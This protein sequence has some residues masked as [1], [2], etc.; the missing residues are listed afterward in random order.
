MFKLFKLLVIMLL[1]S[2]LL[3]LQSC[4]ESSTP[5]P[6][7][8]P[9]KVEIINSSTG[10]SVKTDK[11]AEVIVPA[12]SIANRNDGSSGSVS[13]SIESAVNQSDLPTPIPTM[14]K[15][16]GSIYAFGPSN[17]VFTEPVHI[18]LPA[19]SESSPEGLTI[20]WYNESEKQW[21]LLPLSD[22]DATNKRLG[23]S[24]FELG[25]FAVVRFQ[26]PSSISKS[27]EIMNDKRVGGIRYSHPSNTE[28]YFTLTIKAVTYKYPEIGW[29]NL[30]GYNVGTGSNPT[31]GPRPKTHMMNIPQGTY[32]IELSRVKRGTLS[33]LPGE[34]ETYS[35]PI[36]VTVGPYT[37][38]FGWDAESFQGWTELNLGGGDWRKG[39]PADWPQPTVPY[40][41]GQF[42]A[43]LSW[44]NAG[45]TW[46][47]LDL[48]VF[49]PNGIHV[50]FGNDVSQDG[51]LMLDVDWIDEPGN[52]VENIFSTKPMPK[53]EYK[54]GVF[55]YDGFVP[56]PYE[57]RIIRQGSIVK[58]HRGTATRVGDEEDDLIV[59]QT[60]RID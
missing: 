14:Y 28:Y 41:T 42:Q 51:S 56:K 59:I 10:G 31:G 47:D 57:V 45:S 35:N 49:G 22:I 15:V 9:G 58:T 55:V 18:F 34:R 25:Y 12:G 17:F 46:T 11:G 3:L 37:S 26:N 53:G 50:Y 39:N 4:S 54:I 40:G 20:I 13:F 16:I 24:V 5:T 33:R 27:D 52:A 2:L 38:V 48:H 29:P 43:T 44:Q 32:T 60:F 8:D 7:N 1:T 6:T 36:L 21:I 30:I 23:V 19:E